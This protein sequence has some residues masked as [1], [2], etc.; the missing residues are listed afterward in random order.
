MRRETEIDIQ[1]N[2]SSRARSGPSYVI[3]I[4]AAFLT[5]LKFTLYDRYNGRDNYFVINNLFYNQT[6]MRK[7]DKNINNCIRASTKIA[8]ND[9]DRSGNCR[10][11]NSVHTSV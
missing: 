9:N 8:E 11:Y 1:R 4:N 7:C 10:I 2:L 6:A 3:L 5:I